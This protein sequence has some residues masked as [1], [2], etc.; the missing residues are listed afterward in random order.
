MV[1]DVVHID[2]RKHKCDILVIGIF[3]SEKLMDYASHIDHA[4]DS[5]ISK[6]IKDSKIKGSL[7][8]IYVSET[9]GKIPAEKI[10]V[11][12]LGEENKYSLDVARQVTAIAL[13]KARTLRVRNV[14]LC[15]PISEN[16][17]KNVEDYGCALA[18]GAVLGLYEFLQFKD[19]KDEKNTSK[20]SHIEILADAVSNAS[21]KKG[22]EL[23]MLLGE[24]TNFAR[25]L[26]NQ[27]PNY[28]NTRMLA[29]NAKEVASKCKLKYK[30]FDRKQLEKMN[31]GQIIAVGKGSEVG[32]NLSVLEYEGDK[33]KKHKIALIGKGI[34]FDSG[35]I[36]IKPSSGMDEMKTDMSGAAIVLGIMIAAASLKLKLNIVALI[37]AAE[38]MP[39]GGAFRPGDIVK[40]MNGKT[41]EVLTTDAEGRMILAD[42]IS[43]AE[44]IGCAEIIDIATLTG[45]CSVALGYLSV[46]LFSRDD[47]M[48]D[49]LMKA[50]DQEGERL[51]RMPLYEE[52]KEQLKSS[53]ADIKN[54]GDRLGGAITA[55]L[56][57][58]YFVKK[59]K[60]AHMDIAGPAYFQKE[61]PC[62]PKGA[63][64]VTLRTIVRWLINTCKNQ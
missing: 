44:K 62:V 11:V 54:V 13:K 37:P 49:A 3:Q 17:R 26:I 57:L 39:G 35:G 24:C 41:V 33:N 64:A 51:W 5:I 12:G 25:N 56:Y 55:A 58:E 53:V 20:I 52:Y 38:N 59:A 42:A 16:M 63:S 9:F 14:G 45:A 23:G 4:L 6:N 28:L 29:K 32:P 43:Y 50:S 36:S 60:W 2:P 46:G 18:E 1:I 40:G 8:E 7:F 15:L 48:V 61:T 22:V 21:M 31:M 10:L 34:T 19:S 27:P 30:I 47:K